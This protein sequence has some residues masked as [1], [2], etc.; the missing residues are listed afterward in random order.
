[1]TE[2][3]KSDIDWTSEPQKIT[4]NKSELSERDRPR[5]TL[6][7]LEEVLNE[8]NKFKGIYL[9]N[10]LYHIMISIKTINS[11]DYLILDKFIFCITT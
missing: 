9:V 11:S 1:M 3:E 2:P 5:Y 6:Y 7:E 8:K 4:R 10:I